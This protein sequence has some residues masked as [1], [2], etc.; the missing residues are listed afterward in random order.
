[1]STTILSQIANKLSTLNSTY[2]TSIPDNASSTTPVAVASAMLGYGPKF[3]SGQNYFTGT[4]L[5]AAGINRIFT[6]TTTTIATDATLGLTTSPYNV[7]TNVNTSNIPQTCSPNFLKVHINYQYTPD[8]ILPLFV[9][10]SNLR[11][12]HFGFKC[13][14]KYYL[15]GAGSIRQTAD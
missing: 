9:K 5:D 4:D 8:I 6:N 12:D 13:F 1:M 10:I 15:D 11:V 3:I 14:I 7:N 2:L